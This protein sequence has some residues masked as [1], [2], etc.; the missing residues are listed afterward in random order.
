MSSQDLSLFCNYFYRCTNIP[1]R[2][3]ENNLLQLQLPQVDA[4]YDPLL[5]YYDNLINSS[6]KVSYLITKQFVSYGVVKDC[7]NPARCVL[8]GPITNVFFS[9]DLLIEVMHDASI[10]LNCLEQVTKLFNEATKQSFER[11]LATLCFIHFSVNH[12]SISMEDILDYKNEQILIPIAYEHTSKTFEAKEYQLF[13]NSFQFEKKYL[14]IVEVG[15]VTSLKKLFED[16]VM[17]NPGVLANSALRQ[18]KNIFIVATT[19]ATRAAIK[20][21]VDSENAYQLSDVYIQQME[22]L[23][24]IDEIYNLQYQFLKYIFTCTIDIFCL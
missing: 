23:Q 13:H 19:L 1:I 8:I 12:E 15:D 18:I 21:G 5:K 10:S 4:H 22:K 16:P 9:R 14:G 3:Y 20:G 2:F 11:F 24:S 6:E 7:E 17:I